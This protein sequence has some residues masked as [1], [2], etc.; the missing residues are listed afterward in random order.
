VRVVQLSNNSLTIAGHR[1]A[2]FTVVPAN[3]P[4]GVF[5]G[6]NGGTEY[7]LSSTAALEAN[8]ETGRANTIG[9]WRI[10]NTSSLNR[11]TP[12]LGV[13][14]RVVNTELYGVPP[15]SEQKLGP[16]PL[17]DCEVVACDYSA[18]IPSPTEVEGP[19]DSSDSRMFNTWFDG[20][21]VWGSLSTIVEVGGRIKAGSAWFSFTKSGDV[22]K[23]GYIAVDGNNVIYPGVATLANGK[24]V[25]GVNLV[26]TD[27]YPSQAYMFVDGNGPKGQLH[28][29]AA[30]VGPTD[31]F[32]EYDVEN[33]AGTDPPLKRPRWG[34]YPAAQ[35]SGNSIWIAQE[36]IAQK[37]TFTQFLRDFTCGGKRGAIA[38]WSTRVAQV[39]P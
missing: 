7:L 30:G 2:A 34:D 29:A 28:V 16:T 21:R 4:D 5:T 27:W 26:G 3:A 38:N 11:S 19:L 37:C 33:C 25:I 39:T 24:G 8:N 22:A 12:A 36:Y 1:S 14:R 6:A 9:F 15:V 31:G 35:A 20:N 17:R 32:C 10:T 23:Q 18:G 13:S